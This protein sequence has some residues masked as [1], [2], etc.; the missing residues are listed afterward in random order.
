VWVS[1]REYRDMVGLGA[2]PRCPALLLIP[3]DTQYAYSTI[4]ERG[5][6]YT[7]T[8]DKQGEGLRKVLEQEIGKTG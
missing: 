3:T 7:G 4:P 8:P 6:R 1:D 5:T 2:I